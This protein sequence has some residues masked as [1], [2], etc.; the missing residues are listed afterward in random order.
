[1]VCIEALEEAI[2]QYG[3]P[4]VFNTD[5]GSQFTSVEFTQVLN[6]SPDL[7]KIGGW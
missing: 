2:A 6:D 1:M 4:E 5:Q 3:P 7:Q